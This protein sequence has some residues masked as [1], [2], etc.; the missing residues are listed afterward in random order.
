MAIGYHGKKEQV[1]AGIVVSQQIGSQASGELELVWTCRHKAL[2]LQS[3]LNNYY[4]TKQG[5]HEIISQLIAEKELSGE[6]DSISTAHTALIQYQVSDWGFILKRAKANSWSGGIITT[7]L[8]IAN[9][10]KRPAS[11]IT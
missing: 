10:S 7:L 9:C 2:H 4:F 6:V 1:F 11:G 3:G 8:Y 5:N